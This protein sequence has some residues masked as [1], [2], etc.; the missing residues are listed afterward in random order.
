[1]YSRRYLDW[2]RYTFEFHGIG[3]Q[4][5]S[6]F[7]YHSGLR[8]SDEITTFRQQLGVG[9][10]IG[11]VPNFYCQ[12]CVPFTNPLNIF[13]VLTDALST[14]VVSP[15]RKTTPRIVL[16]NTGSIRF[17]MYKGAF[18]YDDNFIVSPFRDV[19]LYVP[20]VPYSLAK[21]LLAGLNAGG[22]NKRSDDIPVPR[23]I[24]ANPMLGPL[25]DI[26]AR[27]AHEQ[28]RGITRRQVVETVGYITKDD[29]GTDGRLTCNSKGR[30]ALN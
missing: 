24:C 19:F 6:E 4:S 8:V 13:T 16:A 10:L 28:P 25:T 2:N 7:D 3:K 21:T 27:H 12:T 5:D 14:V 22:V 23:D 11:C 29:F 20:S 26:E 9:K 1:V 17:D 18:T 30:K 15:S